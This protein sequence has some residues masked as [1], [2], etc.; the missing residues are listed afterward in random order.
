MK[1]AYLLLICLCLVTSCHAA[2]R[3]KLRESPRL[4][5]SDKEALNS[6]LHSDYLKDS[7]KKVLSD[8]DILIEST[9]IAEGEARTYLQGSRQIRA[10]L[11][12]L[13]GAWALTHEPKY[14][15][16]AIRYLGSLTNWNHISCEANGGT[17]PD[18]DMFFCLMYG[19]QAAEI[20]IMYDLF[21]PE[22]T[23]EEK[24]VFFAVLNRFHLKEALDS[25]RRPPW[26]VNKE[27]SNWNGVCA[28]GMGI[29][30]LAFYDDIP[31]MRKLIPFVEESLGEYF[32]SYVKNGGGCHEGTG[33]WNYGMNYAMRY[34]LYWEHAT[35]KEHPALKIKELGKSLHFP[36]DF[37]GLN[38]GDNDGWHPTGFFFMLSKRM[39][40][41]TAALKAAARLP[42]HVLL[43]KS[44]KRSRR[45]P[46]SAD[47]I[48]AASAIP[49][50]N[51][52]EEFRA[53][54]M[55][56]KV[57]VARVYEGL[58]WAMLA[59]DEAF[60]SLR[61]TARGGTS[62]ISGHGM[63]DLLSFKCRVNGKL[64][65]ADQID[66]YNTVTFTKRGVDL[67][68][69]SAASKSTIFVDGLG[70]EEDVECGTTEVVR[71]DGLLGIR[72]DGS[73]VFMPFWQRRMFI[74]RLFLMVENRYWLVIDHI[75]S[76]AKH[77]R[78]WAESRFHTL[79]Y[80]ERG[81]DWVSL[82]VD[83]QQMMMTFASLG[84]AVMQESKGL[85][86][87][88]KVQTTI[89][90]WMGANATSDNLHVTA[91]NPGSEKLLVKVK[92]A[93]DGKDYVIEVS[94]ED[95][96]SRTI[97]VTADLVLKENKI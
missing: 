36:L 53:S 84:R 56:K 58:G 94:G 40:E 85:P 72:I 76:P 17:P 59:D 64:M 68:G 43:S 74:G 1:R 37:N 30:A 39:N 25:L 95:G 87:A 26:W 90:R 20:G 78:H 88:P 9:P 80:D 57:P 70:C 31:E 71:G 61:L 7:A 81:D 18:R 29:M 67:Y 75:Y 21:R 6:N 79:A 48:Y 97:S 96:Y 89:L 32:K 8:A 41:P 10:N 35:G 45:R 13:T 24:E 63:L 47:L 55:E 46:A 2:R 54:H 27:W 19:E 51:K 28:G 3:L 5:I 33:Y 62:E 50:T 49:S 22:L 38:F 82:K 60:P 86:V 73:G 52:V 69:R 92:K 4:F 14:R 83:D 93:A 11:S 42:E 66:G 34:L 12:N 65:I 91:L 15:K 16:A 44:K 77:D 23:P